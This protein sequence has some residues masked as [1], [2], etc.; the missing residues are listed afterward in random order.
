M[1]KA[2]GSDKGRRSL[3]RR[4]PPKRVAFADDVL[5]D[6]TSTASSDAGYGTS[7]ADTVVPPLRPDAV[8]EM[9]SG[10]VSGLLAPSVYEMSTRSHF[11]A[12]RTRYWPR[13]A[14]MDK[15]HLYAGNV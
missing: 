12:H 3:P 15:E 11:H 1:L 5:V 10:L 9:P 2:A 8:V 13:L 6:G 4:Q 14:K 7:S